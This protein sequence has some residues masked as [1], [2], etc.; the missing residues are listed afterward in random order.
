M[1]DNANH[2]IRLV[3]GGIVS[4]YAGSTTAGA[5]DGERGSATFMSPT[6]LAFDAEGN[7]LVADF[8]VGIRR[9]S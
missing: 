5:A 3:Q 8:G 9:I 1:A 6:G 2:C 4:T 7:L